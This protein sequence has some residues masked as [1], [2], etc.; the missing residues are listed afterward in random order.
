MLPLAKSMF[1]DEEWNRKKKIFRKKFRISVTV[2]K[3][4]RRMNGINSGKSTD[5]CKDGIIRLSCSMLSQGWEKML[6]Q[7]VWVNND[8]P[9]GPEVITPPPC[10]EMAE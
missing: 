5:V 2:W 10:V 6:A 7:F 4:S 1:W 3:R 8:Y 9:P